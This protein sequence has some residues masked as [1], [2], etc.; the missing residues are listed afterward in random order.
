MRSRWRA[1]ITLVGVLG[2]LASCT[3]IAEEEEGPFRRTPGT[4]GA[5]PIEALG[6]SVSVPSAWG[7]LIAVSD[8][9][10]YPASLLWLQDEDGTIRIVTYDH[11][12]AGFWRYAM[13]LRRH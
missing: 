10:S 9:D 6:D 12:R 3:R 1:S 2:V 4:P 11:N 13:V 8:Y 5:V 7:D